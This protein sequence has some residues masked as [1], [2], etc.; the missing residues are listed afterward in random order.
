M[1]STAELLAIDGLPRPGLELIEIFWKLLVNNDG[2]FNEFFGLE[3]IDVFHKIID[4]VS[5]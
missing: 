5:I 2:E 4:Q 1:R 3:I